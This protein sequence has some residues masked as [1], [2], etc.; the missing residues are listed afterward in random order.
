METLQVSALEPHLAA[1]LLAGSAHLDPCG[2]ATE[3][4]TEAMTSA[5]QCFAVTSN[6]SQAVYV[7]KVKNGVAWVSA[8][9]GSGA[10]PW[11]DILLPMI[12]AQAKGCAAVGFQTTRR[13]GVKKAQAQGYRITG[14]IM[15]KDLQ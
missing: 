7:V 2:M 14:W 12:E 6:T 11:G 15:K 13:G 3:Q 10:T 1:Q 9:K 4:D 8:M 5:G